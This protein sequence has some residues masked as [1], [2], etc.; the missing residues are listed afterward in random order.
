ML[1]SKVVNSLDKDSD[2]PMCF[3]IVDYKHNFCVTSLYHTNKAIAQNI[4]SGS[5]VLIRD[6]HLVLIQLSFKGYQYN[7]QCIK[8]TNTSSIMV[9]GQTLYQKAATTEIISKTF[10]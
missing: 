4:R 7:Y 3:L 5:E 8:I 6:P 9:N 10:S 1:S 2:V